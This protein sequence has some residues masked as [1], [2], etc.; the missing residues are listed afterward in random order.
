MQKFS[1]RQTLA[2][3]LA[4]GATVAVPSARADGAS[5]RVSILLVNDI[6]RIE[7]KNGRGGMARFAAVLKAERARALAEDSH[8]IRVHAGDT[9]SPSL[10]SSFDQGAT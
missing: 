4:A 3:I 5:A 7:E 9:L 2:S 1:R 6:Y 8:L 10:L